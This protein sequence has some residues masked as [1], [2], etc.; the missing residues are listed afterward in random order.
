[1]ISREIQLVETFV[2]PEKR[3]R[4]KGFLSSPKRRRKFLDELYH[5][6]DFIPGCEIELRGPTNTAEG[7]I[8]DLRRRG[9]H[10][11]CYV[12]SVDKDFDGSTRPLADVI[13]HVFTSIEGTL[14][15]CVPGRL[16]Y[17]EGEAPKNRFILTGRRPQ[18]LKSKA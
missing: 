17:Y 12:M 15:C 14:I 13:R 5:F 7:L 16:A 1:M 9:A 6:H 18:S 11:D 2:V 3:E 10:A 8:A 4:Y